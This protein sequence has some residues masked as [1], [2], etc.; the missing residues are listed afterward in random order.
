M[1]K[2]MLANQKLGLTAEAGLFYSLASIAASEMPGDQALQQCLDIVCEYVEWPV[3]HL[4]V[5][6]SDGS[7]ELA[8][9]TV[10]HLD[11][12]ER[13]EAFRTVTERTRF[14]PGVGLPGRVLQSGE[15]AWIPDVQQDENF[16][17]NKAAG[18]I[19]VRGAFA[20]PIKAG[21][22][23]V[24]VLE[25]FADRQEEPNERVLN[26]MGM[27]A[28]QF[29]RIL[30]RKRSEEALRDA[31][32]RLRQLME[33]IPIGVF[34]LD[35]SG[36]PT[37]ANP[38]AKEL[39]GRG[40]I[41]DT[42]TDQLG[43]VYQATIAGTD[44]PYPADR[45]PIVR[46]LAGERLTVDDL[47]VTR[48]G[49]KTLA[50]EVWGSPVYDSAG[51]VQYAMAAF[52]DITERKRAEDA[53]R[54]T[55]EMYR[56]VVDNANDAMVINVGAQVVFV[57]HAYVALF[58]LEDEAQAV[59]LSV[60]QFSHPEDYDLVRERI[61]ARERGEPVPSRFEHRII[62][63]DGN[64]RTVE[65]SS[66]SITFRGQPAWLRVL[67]DVTERKRAEE[68]IRVL[69][70]E[71]EQR[72]IELESSMKELDAFSYSVSH[73]LRAPLRAM[74]GFSRILAEEH[75]PQLVPEAQHYLQ[76]VR[77]NAQQMGR[78]I[79][80]LLMFS[81]LG[82][83][84]LRLQTVALADLVKQALGDL[85][86]ER[87]ERRIEISVG[88]LPTCR[89]D[90]ALLRQ[91]YI[92]LIGN[93]LKYTR[94]N[95]TAVIEV[96]CQQIDGEHVYRIKDNGAG[97]DMRYADKL[98]GVFQRLHRSEDYEGT[99]VGL[100][101]AQRI[102]HRHGGRIWAEAEINKGATFYFTLSGG[103]AN[104]TTR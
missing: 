39:L 24:A 37:Y 67:R 57:N 93:A 69:N 8:P 54:E 52:I 90:P 97:F 32:S 84:Q 44:Q 82:R 94:K 1:S 46:A 38:V 16:P 47:E 25:F 36:K 99:G 45:M 26:V 6:A 80:D 101:I 89:A 56:A 78:L 33:A 51:R 18:E 29:S 14:P 95:Q 30:E 63:Q 17:R 77:D 79:D 55:E 19:G 10:W 96:D 76:L 91:V 11:D 4:Y 7:G 86:S 42:A 72:V 5:D 66:V 98:F 48:P 22:Q 71:L 15:P 34:V 70:Q 59:G 23:I 88:D 3:G 2:I 41:A 61:L 20:I 100:A 81:R 65:T 87:E 85:Q 35:S 49:G 28:H 74:D 92:N 60:Y 21:S 83:Q 75:A 73:D 103:P 13:F 27:V 62:R 68:E 102:I 64:V 53:L 104:G 50:L 40:I 31:E 58:G 43:E 9:A 12:P